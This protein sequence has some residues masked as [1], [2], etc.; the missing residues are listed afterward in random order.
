VNLCKLVTPS[1][2]VYLAAVHDAMIVLAFMH[3]DLHQCSCM[4]AA[5]AVRQSWTVQ[6][7]K[8]HNT[9]GLGIIIS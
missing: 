3:G 8:V 1:L 5:R 2:R 7:C 6:G 4:L 9:A